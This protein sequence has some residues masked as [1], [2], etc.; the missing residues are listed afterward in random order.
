VKLTRRRLAPLA[1]APW[2]V[3]PSAQAAGVT[4]PQAMARARELRDE[5]RRGGD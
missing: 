4:L 1:F 5:A 3:S 2:C